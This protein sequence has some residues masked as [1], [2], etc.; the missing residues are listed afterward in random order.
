LREERAVA[1]AAFRS[2]VEAASIDWEAELLLSLEEFRDAGGF[3]RVQASLRAQIR[4]EQ[5]NESSIP[6]HIHYERY[7]QR[8]QAQSVPLRPAPVYRRDDAANQRL[9]HLFLADHLNLDEAFSAV[10]NDVELY[11]AGDP[12]MASYR[13]G[14]RI[15]ILSG[16]RKEMYDAIL[17]ELKAQDDQKQKDQALLE[18]RKRAVI[19][20]QAARQRLQ[21][22]VRGFGA[23]GERC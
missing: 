22:G 17:A 4:L 14:L 19:E 9:C 23:R 11:I 2:A 3:D 20:E 7:L 8:N 18:E 21:F 1:R 16:V 10:S 6:A 15:R 5:C 13:A 12:T